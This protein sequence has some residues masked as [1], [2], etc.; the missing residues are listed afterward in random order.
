MK[1]NL[2]KAAYE[3]RWFDFADGKLKIRP[4]PA[5]KTAF[6]IKDGA[7][8]VYGEQNLEKFIYCLTAWEGITYDDGKPLELTK[9]LKKQIF[10]FR[11][12]KSGDETMSDFVIQ[13]ADELFAEAQGQEK[14]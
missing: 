5:S 9:E 6:A 1:L 12:C 10:D 3:G 7:F 4:Y 13:K 2:E 14:N 8:I 11:L